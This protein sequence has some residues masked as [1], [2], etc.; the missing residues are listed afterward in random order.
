MIKQ[1]DVYKIGKIGKP[2]GINGELSFIF[3]DD[4][5]DSVDSE[6]LILMV[7][8]IL[9]PFFMDEY[10]FKNEDSALVKFCDV[11]NKEQAQELTGC[12]VYFPRN[13]ADPTEHGVSIHQT[14]GFTLIDANKDN[15]AIG[16]IINVDDSTSNILFEIK[17]DNGSIILIP[18]SE[19]FISDLNL[20]E[21]KITVCLPEGLLD[22]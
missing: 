11:N 2:H 18:A 17:R 13:M 1:E 9:V 22:L 19:D 6:Y 14:I 21:R 10:R 16:N 5:F 7:K 20:T 3:N 4:I 8:G 12:D 15:T